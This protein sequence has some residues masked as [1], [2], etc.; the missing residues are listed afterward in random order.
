LAVALAIASSYKNKPLPEK[1]VFFAE[2]G[3]TG[4]LKKV[5]AGDRRRKEAETLGYKVYS[6]FKNIT[7]AI[8]KNLI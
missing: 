3:L 4:E 7:Q 1:S 2:I 8:E 5:Q 6:N